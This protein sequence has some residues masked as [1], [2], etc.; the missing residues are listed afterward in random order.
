MF[1]PLL[2]ASLL[3]LVAAPDPT[4]AV[5]AHPFGLLVF[6]LVG[7]EEETI[8]HLQLDVVHKPAARLSPV[9]HLA[10]TMLSA[11]FDKLDDFEKSSLFRYALELGARY[12]IW[13]ERGWYAEGT[14]G[15]LIET[16]DSKW[17]ENVEFN[18]QTNTATN[19]LFGKVDNTFQ[20]PYAM[21]YLGWASDPTKRLRWDLG[22]GLGYAFLGGTD[23]LHDIEWTGNPALADKSHSVDLFAAAPLVIDLNFGIG[24]N[25]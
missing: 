5:T 23:E 7:D 25:F 24:V 10:V 14:L 2:L 11:D 22:L 8:A 20:Q 1:L 21:V 6:P 3:S 4:F 17:L 12:R 16:Y 9:G 19:Q 13:P 18:R 15:Y